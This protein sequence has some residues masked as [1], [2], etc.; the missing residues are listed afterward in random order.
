[1]KSKRTKAVKKAKRRAPAKKK[2]AAHA[3]V[4][5]PIAQ[6]IAPVVSIG[7]RIHNASVLIAAVVVLAAL[8]GLAAWQHLSDRADRA[9]RIDDAAFAREIDRAVV[10]GGPSDAGKPLFA[11]PASAVPAQAKADIKI[12]PSIVARAEA[13]AKPQASPAA[14]RAQNPQRPRARHNASEPRQQNRTAQQGLDA[15]AAVSG[16]ELIAE[17]RKYLGGNPTGWDSEW[18]G[19]FLDM[20]LKKTGYKGGGNLA[21][22]YINYGTRLA[23][24]EVGAI[25]VFTRKGGG[26]VGI[27]TGIDANG[28][29]IVI[30]GNYNDR[31]AIATYPAARALAYVR[32]V[33]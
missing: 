4:V 6:A 14:P 29:P 22:G 2:I 10:E 7:N 13:K 20:V 26:H 18:C 31:V 28:N 11:V 24:P 32:P 8:A 19:R 33:Q 16:N 3:A 17:A 12:D 21:R 27:V 1:M 15:M 5:A 23:G 25:A 9:A 30:S